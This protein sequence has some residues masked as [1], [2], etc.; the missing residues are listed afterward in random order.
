MVENFGSV[1][2][3]IIFII[4]LLGLIYYAYLTYLNPKQLINDYQTG[5][6]SIVMIRVVGSFV[7][8]YV[9]IG[10]ILL[11]TSINGAWIYFVSGLMISSFQLL[12]DLGSR[13][14]IIDSNYKVINK[15]S[16]T[17]IAVVFI[18]INVIL[19]SGLSD[20]IYHH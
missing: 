19:I 10:I 14:K 8:S 6:D 9:V 20:R 3:L 7:L 16:D 2:Y 13:M 11:F 15:N 17:I 5:D 18:V 12:Y 1:F 4:N